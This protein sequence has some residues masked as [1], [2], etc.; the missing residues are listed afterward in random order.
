[1]DGMKATA[2]ALGARKAAPAAQT[3]AL[4]SLLI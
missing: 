1:M 2:R 3:A 4:L